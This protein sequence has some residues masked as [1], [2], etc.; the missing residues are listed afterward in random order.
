MAYIDVGVLHAKYCRA[1]LKSMC[2]SLDYSF[3]LNPCN[4]LCLQSR[5]ME[6]SWSAVED[7][8]EYCHCSSFMSICKRLQ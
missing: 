8:C 3:F 1:F 5:R 7:Q 6:I 4:A 2:Q